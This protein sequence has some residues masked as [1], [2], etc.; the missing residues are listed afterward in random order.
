M[1]DNEHEDAA[2]AT[3]NVFLRDTYLNF[4]NVKHPSNYHKFYFRE[5]FSRAVEL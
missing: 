2:K 1:E 5:Q 3:G 4:P